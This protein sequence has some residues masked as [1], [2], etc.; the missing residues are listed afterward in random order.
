M[1]AIKAILHGKS[2]TDWETDSV[3]ISCSY[4]SEFKNAEAVIHP[5]VAKALGID[6]DG[7][8]WVTIGDK[9]FS[10]F[11]LVRNMNADFWISY[12]PSLLIRIN[13]TKGSLIIRHGRYEITDILV[14]AVFKNEILGNDPKK[15]PINHITI[16]FDG[17]CKG[18]PG[19]GGYGY[20]IFHGKQENADTRHLL[21]DG[22]GYIEDCTS[23]VSEY[24]GLI[25]ALIQAKRLNAKNLTICGDS[26]LVIQQIKGNYKVRSPKMIPLY[27][28]VYNLL[29]HFDKCYV[30]HVS[31]GKNKIADALANTAV[32]VGNPHF[33]T[34][35]YWHNIKEF[36]INDCYY[37]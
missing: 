20:C 7:T 32:E 11:T 14:P 31:R 9:R 26:E 34:S 21:A 5:R 17:C 25:E 37:C 19:Y 1:A 30:S 18:N 10:L 33:S 36:R 4:I 2:S 3:F 12:N 16:F 24:N 27:A 6:S 28:K 35:Y 22:Y 23:N 13:K 8:L 15:T 29:Q